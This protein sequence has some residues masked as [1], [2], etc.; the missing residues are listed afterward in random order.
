M[1]Q[2]YFA[3]V[4]HAHLPF[5]RHPEQDFVLEEDWLFEAITETYVPL[6]LMFEGLERDGIDFRLTMSMTPPL[7]SMLRDPLLQE[8]YDEYLSKL[9][10]LAQLE[11][12]RNVTYGH[13]KYLAEFYVEEFYKVRD[14]WER[15]DRDLVTAFK[16]FQD[17]GNLEIITCGATHGYLPLMQMYP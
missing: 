10:E 5:V 2:G 17:S 15:Y 12:E 6:L 11:A 13:V 7:V 14:L 8:R 16:K 4:L 3:L 1:S 9:E